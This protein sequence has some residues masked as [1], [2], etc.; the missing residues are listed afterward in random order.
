VAWEF[1][2]SGVEAGRR[3]GRLCGFVSQASAAA[4]ALP[5][6]RPRLHCQGS[7]VAVIAPARSAACCGQAWRGLPRV[8]GTL[9][10]LVRVLQPNARRI[11]RPDAGG[12]R[13]V[14][15]RVDQKSGPAEVRSLIR[16]EAQPR[17]GGVADAG[18]NHSAA[19]RHIGDVSPNPRKFRQIRFRPATI[20]SRSITC[21][22]SRKV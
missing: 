3:S 16:W 4:G 7:R 17:P 21:P 8:D 5:R 14:W 19:S 2:L 20:A 1:G 9:K 22:L 6:C 18:Q 15:R 12:W 13:Q 10:F 11:V